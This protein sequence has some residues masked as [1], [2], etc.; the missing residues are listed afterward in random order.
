MRHT[1]TLALLTLGL[2]TAAPLTLSGTVSAPSGGNVKGTHVIAC[3]PKGDACD[4]QFSVG[5]QV[6]A[7]GPHAAFS[8]TVKKAGEYQL[9]AWKD[10]NGSGDMDD[11]DYSGFFSKAGSGTPGRVAAPGTNLAF[12]MTV[13]GRSST[14]NGDRSLSGTVEA[15]KGVNLEGTVVIACV[16]RGDGCDENASKMMALDVAGTKASF[17]IEGLESSAY[18]LVAWKDVNRNEQFDDGDYVARLTSADGQALEVKAPRANIALRLAKVGEPASLEQPTAA[19]AANP[20]PVITKGQPGYVTGQVFDSLGRPLPGASVK[21]DPAVSGYFVHSLGEYRT[22]AKGAYKA[23]LTPEVAWKAT[24]STSVSWLDMPMCLPSLPYGDGALFF[25]ADGAVRH[26][27]IDTNVAHLIVAQ[28][29]V[30]TT[31]PAERP[32][33]IGDQRVNKFKV[34]LRPLGNA[35]DGARV[36]GVDTVVSVA[37]GGWSTDSTSFDLNELPLAR[38]ELKVAYVESDGSLT[39]LVVRNTT[40]RANAPFAGS[41]VVEFEDIRGCA[42]QSKIEFQFP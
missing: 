11:G 10:M 16:V 8:L 17:K 30:V 23:R 15:P 6:T 41:T 32:R 33:F 13:R 9:I 25:A 1:L 18:R 42:A 36:P 38:Y 24:A 12:S 28:Q 27:K 31:N 14:S 37:K 2:A 40:G 5:T 39:P 35:V 20:S 26:F 19:R 34:T 29:F 22:D 3:F 7:S 4:E 21:I